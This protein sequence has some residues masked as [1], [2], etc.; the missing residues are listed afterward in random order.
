MN[1]EDKKPLRQPII[2]RELVQA[3]L[4]NSEFRVLCVLLYHSRAAGECYPSI[5]TISKE[6]QMV[7]RSVHKALN[8]LV[9]K[10]F[11]ETE[12]GGGRNN[13]NLYKLKPKESW[14]LAAAFQNTVNP[15]TIATLSPA[16]KG[17]TFVDI[18]RNICKETPQQLSVNPATIATQRSSKE[19]EKERIEE[20]REAAEPP[21]STDTVG[22]KTQ[23]I[24]REMESPE[25]PIP[26]VDDDLPDMNYP[27]D[28]SR[29]LRKRFEAAGDC[30]PVTDPVRDEKQAGD[31]SIRLFEYDAP[32]VAAAVDRYLALGKPSDKRYRTVTALSAAIENFLSDSDRAA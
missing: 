10:A 19:R 21:L 3:A 17:A 23:N 11:I 27:D 14:R 24:N 7:E 22:V 25:S 9:D 30:Y 5:A 29:W 31:L 28:F 12:E 18:P 1:D 26:D 15:A 16:E 6:S 13:T 20:E 2:L 32:A 4:T 8:G